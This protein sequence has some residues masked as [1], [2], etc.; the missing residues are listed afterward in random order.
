MTAYKRN[1]LDTLKQ[2]EAHFSQTTENLEVS[3]PEIVQIP[4]EVME[5]PSSFHLSAK[6]SLPFI[7]M[8]QHGRYT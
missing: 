2:R 6:L 1:Q 3:S 7:L 4:K 8:T 5:D